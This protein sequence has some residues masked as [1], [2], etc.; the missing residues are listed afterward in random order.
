MYEVF[1]RKSAQKALLKLP[2]EIRVEFQQAFRLLA[3]SPTRRDLDVKSLQGREGYRLRI[4]QWRAIYR[5]EAKRLIIIV[6]D[7]GS[8]GDIYK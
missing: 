7:I 4:S 1:Y 6:L 8:R 5:V 2:S 3:E